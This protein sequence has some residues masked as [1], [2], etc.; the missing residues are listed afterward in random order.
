MYWVSYPSTVWNVSKYGVFSGPYF[1]AFGLNTER[2][3]VS[4]HIQSECG[5]I[6]SRKN[7]VFGHFS[8]SDQD[9]YLRYFM[10]L[11]IQ[12]TGKSLCIV[13]KWAYPFPSLTAVTQ[14]FNKF[15]SLSAPRQCLNIFDL[16]E[17]IFDNFP[18]SCFISSH[19]LWQVSHDNL[20][21]SKCFEAKTI[22]RLLMT[23]ENPW[24]WFMSVIFKRAHSILQYCLL[25]W[26]RA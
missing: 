22:W 2:Y 1:P 13:W 8:H 5:K 23:S 9:A 11:D 14:S 7:S 25:L 24:N 17:Q 18:N 3:F 21:S 4:L 26:D 15:T 20:L 19:M 6:Q 12:K 10:L 16:S